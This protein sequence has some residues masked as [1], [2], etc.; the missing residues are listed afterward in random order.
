M[1]ITSR[2]LYTLEDF[3]EYQASILLELLD[4]ASRKN[5]NSSEYLSSVN[6]MKDKLSKEIFGN[7]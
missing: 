5:V 6:E 2:T 4:E 3:T 7:K 1:K